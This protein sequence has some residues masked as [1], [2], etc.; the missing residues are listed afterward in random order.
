MTLSERMSASRLRDATQPPAG[1]SAASG[2]AGAAAPAGPM[3][4]E[5]IR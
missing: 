1:A 2:A 4:N 5:E 3:N